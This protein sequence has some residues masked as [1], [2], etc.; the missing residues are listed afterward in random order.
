[1]LSLGCWAGQWGHSSVLT[2]CSPGK[3]DPSAQWVPQQL[4]GLWKRAGMEGSLLFM[5]S[6]QLLS[7]QIHFLKEIN[8]LQERKLVWK[9]QPDWL[10]A[11]SYPKAFLLSGQCG[12]LPAFFYQIKESCGILTK[13][14]VC[15]W[16]L[17]GAH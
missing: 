12:G 5:L 17:P 2:A 10:E 4:L 14:I 1:M 9:V 11:L 8:P 15:R 7:L 16:Q 3:P 13:I 6:P